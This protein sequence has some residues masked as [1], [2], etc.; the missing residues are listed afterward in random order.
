MKFNPIKDSDI[1]SFTK[2]SRS[3]Q[4]MIHAIR[5]SII[6]DKIQNLDIAINQAGKSTIKP[7]SSDL[8]EAIIE[9]CE[10]AV[11]RTHQNH[12]GQNDVIYI[13][14]PD[15]NLMTSSI[16]FF[17]EILTSLSALKDF[18][19]SKHKTLIDIDDVGS[20]T[21]KV[22]KKLTR[23][24]SI[25]NLKQLPNTHLV[26]LNHKIVNLNTK[27]IHDLEDVE[28]SFDI[29]SKNSINYIDEMSLTKTTLDKV[30]MYKHIIDRIMKDWSD[31]RE[32]VEHLMWQIIYAV[33]QNDNHDKFVVIKGPG[34]NGKSTFMRL[35]SK[36]AGENNT[37]Y[38]N[39]HQFGDPNAINGIDMSTRVIIGDD[40]ATNHKLSDIAL[41]NLKSIVTGDA[42]SLPMKYS[43][44]V[45]VRTNSLFVQGTNTDIS[46][47]ENNSAVK[48]RMILL[49]WTNT[50]FRSKSKTELTFDLNEL[51]KKQLFIDVWANMCLSK[52]DDFDE[53]TIPQSVID[54]TEE[55]IESNDAIKQFLDDVYPT[56]NLYSKIPIK[57]LYA[58]YSRWSK[59]NN[60]SARIMKL[61]MFVKHLKTHSTSFGFQ[62]PTKESR[63]RFKNYRYITS[64]KRALDVDDFQLDQQSCIQPQQAIS[65]K[66]LQEFDVNSIDINNVDDQQL[67]M[68]LMLAYDYNRSDVISKFGQLIA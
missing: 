51:M 63:M 27:E 15:A 6:S 18:D 13:Y 49:N 39:I 5:K 41:S 3:Y 19:G 62:P 68:I 46:L 42:I 25:R 8:V 58:A 10:V 31:E 57:G 20:T 2:K 59:L 32:D 16:P 30:T 38:A 1:E 37:H 54:A 9:N 22:M 61:Q 34:G 17:E 12:S 56:I 4:D 24:R 14:N 11:H 53:F 7:K 55:M 50:D 23:S 45:V 65:E 28:L 36:I 67:Q 35:L 64:L 47:Y 33:M 60:P 44:N 21:L 48:S 66:E 40:A 43:Q 29:L 26:M 52:I